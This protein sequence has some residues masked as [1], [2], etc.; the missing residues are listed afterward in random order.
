MYVQLSPTGQLVPA[1]SHVILRPIMTWVYGWPLYDRDAIKIAKKHDLV[2]RPDADDYDYIEAA[3]LWVGRN[4][5]SPRALCCWVGEDTNLVFAAYVDYRD[6]AYPPQKVFV[7]EMMS[8]KQ[9][10]RLARCMPLRDQDWYR[11]C[12][13]SQP[14]R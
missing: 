9:A 11:Y 5:G 14:H 3:Q 4:A 6:R 8:E 7:D 10:R 12:D 13:G 2:Q 1:S